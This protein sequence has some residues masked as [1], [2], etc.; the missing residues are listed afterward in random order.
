M[1][2]VAVRYFLI[3]VLLGGVISCK[4]SD[5]E[6]KDDDS[7]VVVP[8]PGDGDGGNN[9][10]EVIKCKSCK[11]ITSAA[12]LSALTLSAGDS[13]MMKA[14]DWNNQR[15][16]FKGKG[17]AQQPIVLIAE[18]LGGVIMKGTSSL[19]IDG[20]Y[21]EV[22]GL[23]FKD[24]L[25]PANVTLLIAFTSSSK[26][27][28]LTN[29]SIVDYNPA[30]ATTDYRW[31]SINGTKNR[32]DHCYI[33]GK[34]HQ[35]A[36]VVIW[37]R[38][39]SLEHRIDHNYFGTRPDLGNNGGETI[40]VGTSDYYLS[41]SNVIIE[42]NIFDKCNGETEIISNKMS[43]NII[44]NNLF[45]ESRGT[46]CL[47]HGNGTEVYG[48][49]I[50]GNNVAAAGGIRIVGESHL[51]YNNYI[52]GITQT[53]QYCAISLLDGVPNAAPSEYF[54]VK[55]AKIV[56]NTIVNCSQAF[57]IGA[58]K[59]GNGRTV[60]PANCTLANNLVQQKVGATLLKLADTPENF[61]YVGNM[62]YAVGATMPQGFV[63][64]SQQL[65]ITVF[66]TYEPQSGSPA[67]GAFQGTFPFYTSAD[68]GA[69]A[70]DDMHKALLK[71]EGIGPSWVTGL[72]NA[73]VI[74]A[75]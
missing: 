48:N 20:E 34:A 69:K 49:Y 71:S 33:K 6:K 55:N 61:T 36:T 5:K 64:I 12:E 29:T 54:Q 15:L 13:V 56:G 41:E 42:E 37:G 35:G 27:C 14:G 26:G 3:L 31:V 52:Q 73:L 67:F 60:P 4:K 16:V 46:L 19:Q 59:G 66:G 72:G 63:Q 50:I 68:V 8:P 28:R 57:E 74:K 24:G 18:K 75:L 40:R 25:A 2:K 23:N 1:I 58:G 11:V 9:D 70:L 30:S 62:A 45:F 17:T 10:G 51:V 47:R 22:N 44:R 65:G 7:G 38:N 21:L 32:L 43:K 53:G 39:S